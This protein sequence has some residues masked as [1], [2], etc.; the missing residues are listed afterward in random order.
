M[1]VRRVKGGFKYGSKG[2]V[3]KSRKG[4]LAQMRAIKWR[5]GRKGK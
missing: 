3:Y 4:A 5:Q 1:P 2:H